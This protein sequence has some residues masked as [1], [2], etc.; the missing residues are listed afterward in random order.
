MEAANIHQITKITSNSRHPLSQQQHVKLNQF[1]PGWI[2]LAN[3]R[4][5]S[6]NHGF[7]LC[8]HLDVAASPDQG[9]SDSY[10]R[11]DSSIGSNYV[12]G[13]TEG[14]ARIAIA[15]H[16]NLYWAIVTARNI[17]EYV[18]A[19]RG[20]N[21]EK[22]ALQHVAQYLSDEVWKKAKENNVPLPK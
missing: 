20:H 4:H 8:W 22:E 7:I 6:P 12:Y 5:K 11:R 1:S 21:T 9:Y 10:E 18:H 3:P 17:P 14:D 19:I 15:T 13:L 16:D 2:S